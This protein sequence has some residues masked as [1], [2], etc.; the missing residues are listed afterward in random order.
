MPELLS[1]KFMAVIGGVVILAFLI[2]L[3]FRKRKSNIYASARTEPCLII[4][5]KGPHSVGTALIIT[6]T[7]VSSHPIAIRGCT[8]KLKGIPLS[9]VTFPYDGWGNPAQA[10]VVTGWFSGRKAISGAEE[11][12]LQPSA[13]QPAETKDYGVFIALLKQVFEH[14][15]G[16]VA[17]SS[18]DSSIPNKDNALR[19]D[20]L[21][22]VMPWRRRNKIVRLQ[23]VVWE[24]SGKSYRAR[25]TNLQL[26]DLSIQ[27]LERDAGYESESQGANDKYS[28]SPR[29][30]DIERRL[31]SDHTQIGIVVVLPHEH[32]AMLS[33]IDNP[34]QL[35]VEGRGAGR[36]YHYGTVPT[37]NGPR[38]VL[39]ALG[40]PG[41]NAAAVRTTL[42]I[43][44]FPDIEHVLMVGIA[45]A[46]PWPEKPTEHVR[47]GDIVVSSL[48]GVVQYDFGKQYADGFHPYPPPRP[49]S[50]LLSE[51]ARILHSEE[52]LTASRPWEAH[53][54]RGL[55]NLGW[56]RPSPKADKLYV[57]DRSSEF[58]RHPFDRDRRNGQPRVFYGPIGSANQVLKDAKKRIMVRNRFGL[59]AVEMESSGV[60][61]ATQIGAVGYLTI[62]GTCD[63]CDRRK[64][65]H[66]QRYAAIAAAAWARSLLESLSLGENEGKY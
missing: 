35:I 17:E 31:V 48:G 60:A 8:L 33:M 56:K 40:E 22:F 51:G 52:L 54:L 2:L 25:R 16:V 47:L 36:R 1:A 64:S 12:G 19:T 39:V 26:T 30:R 7:N 24:A 53:I 20:W 11:W 13:I 38:L 29:E 61:D 44:H 4:G 45:G 63:Y 18:E 43:Q 23:P 34:K 62:R 58:I 27:K 14:Y 3:T 42:M 49:P 66:W 55:A 9:I 41:N 50:A 59:K 6:V 37:G 28:S 21:P 46:I 65:D 57:S 5:A 32:A 15:S 10:L